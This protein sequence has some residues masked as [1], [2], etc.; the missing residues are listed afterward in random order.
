MTPT[1]PT[2]GS[3][4]EAAD[5]LLPW[6]VTGR[7]E[8][9][10]RLRLDAALAADP[11]LRRRRAL[12]Q[13][14]RDEVVRA[15][16]AAASPVDEARALERLFAAID[17]DAPASPASTTT[18]TRPP[19]RPTASLL[20]RLEG[21]IEALAPRTLTYAAAGV[22]ALALLQATVIASFLAAGGGREPEYATASDPNAAPAILRGTFLLV[23]F[24][25]TASAEEVA[26]FL[27]ARNGQIVEGPKPG[28][29]YRVRIADAPLAG[30]ELD[31]AIATFRA[32][33]AVI[34][35]AAPAGP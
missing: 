30:A 7:L 11:E 34:R 33:T 31:R 9:S 13:E 10:D 24:Q 3:Q 5:L 21:W 29:L 35:F 17:A 2:D 22:L 8:P 27:L 23:G 1:K 16:A 32:E 20:G 19:R 26:H 4:D 6:H 15:E 28:G 14:E 18:S 25:P 12:A